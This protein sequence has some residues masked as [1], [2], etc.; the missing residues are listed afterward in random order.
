MSGTSCEGGRVKRVLPLLVLLSALALGAEQMRTLLPKYAKEYRAYADDIELIAESVHARYPRTFYAESLGAW[1]DTIVSLLAER[2]VKDTVVEGRTVLAPATGYRPGLRI[3]EFDYEQL[4]RSID[5]LNQLMLFALPEKDLVQKSLALPTDYR[6][7]EEYGPRIA[8]FKETARDIATLAA[9]LR[10]GDTSFLKKK[11]DTLLNWGDLKT[12]QAWEKTNLQMV[13]IEIA[14]TL[15]DYQARYGLQSD[16][17]NWL[18]LGLMTTCPFLRD[19]ERGPSHWEPI[20]RWTPVALNATDGQVMMAGQLGLNYYF[21]SNA[22]APLQILN[23]VGLAAGC[24]DPEG[25][26]ITDFRLSRASPGL[27]LHVGR[28]QV[29]VFY[30]RA[31]RKLKLMSTLDFQIIPGAF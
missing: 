22:W 24:A 10:R 11:H 2:E 5:A 17:V 16:R 23:H 9:L 25:T 20:A 13:K 21:F 12:W 29:G 27:V 8:D 3:R 4:G 19:N 15:A 30:S 1:E 6:S 7:S 26:S 14:R 28:G 18:E 31:T